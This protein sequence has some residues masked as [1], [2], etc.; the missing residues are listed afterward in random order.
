VSETVRVTAGHIAKGTRS[1]PCACPVAHAVMDAL[2]SPCEV[3]LYV[4]RIYI[5]PDAGDLV[6]VEQPASVI[7]FI[8]A[9]DDGQPVQP[10]EFTLDWQPAAS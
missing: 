8:E 9:F 2:P 1:D 10:F 5:R 4:G 6:I 7:D 3:D